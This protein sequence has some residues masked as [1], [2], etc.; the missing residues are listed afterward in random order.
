MFVN[1]HVLTAIVAHVTWSEWTKIRTRKRGMVSRETSTETLYN[2]LLLLLLL[3]YRQ[4][5]TAVVFSLL[6]TL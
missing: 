1:G 3:L 2:L 4:S 6:A 5:R